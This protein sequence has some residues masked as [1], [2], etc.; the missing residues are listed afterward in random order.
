MAT[1]KF[2]VRSI[3]F[4]GLSDPSKKVLTQPPIVNPK[5]GME[6]D[7][8]DPEFPVVK[9]HEFK[10]KYWAM[11]RSTSFYLKYMTEHWAHFNKARFHG[12]MKPPDAF[13]L[14]KDVDAK[15]MRLRGR[16]RFKERRLEVSPNLFNAPHEGWINRT[17]IHEM[18]HQYVYDVQ[19]ET[20]IS[21]EKGH[22]PLWKAAMRMA[23]L[24]PSRFDNTANEMF[25]DAKEKKR[26]APQMNF[27]ERRRELLKTRV[28][29]QRPS[30]GYPVEVMHLEGNALG[31]LIGPSRQG[32]RSKNEWFYM[33]TNGFVQAIPLVHCL[34]LYPPD[35]APLLTPEMQKKAQDKWDSLAD[36]GLIRIN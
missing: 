32:P 10:I 27:Q 3:T 33:N 17:L 13:G 29:V 26:H 12:A 31:V 30:L 23:N 22:G 16:F 8:D 9:D 18:A 25:F 28:I 21:I 15:R 19:G 34:E 2:Q 1:S 11:P 6:Y 20:E 14:L 36:R 35:R 24:P 7:L 4:E 5:T